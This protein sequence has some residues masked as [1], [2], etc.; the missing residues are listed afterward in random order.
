MKTLLRVLL[1]LSLP[2]SA[3]AENALEQQRQVYQKLNRLLDGR[4]AITVSDSRLPALFLC[5]I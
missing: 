3:S 5:G 2:F 1:C 4:I